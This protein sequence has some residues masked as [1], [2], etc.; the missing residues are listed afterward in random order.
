MTKLRVQRFDAI[1]ELP[2]SVLSFWTENSKDYP[3]Q[4]PNWLL[5]WWDAYSQNAPKKACMYVVFLD[6]QPIAVA[7]FY[8]RVPLLGIRSLRLMGDKGTCTDH[9]SLIIDPL[10]ADVASS[11]LARTLT[12]QAG[13]IWDTL[14]FE[15]VDLE[16]K[17]LNSLIRS[18]QKLKLQFSTQNALDCWV[19]KLQ[20]TWDQYL[21]SLSKNHRK[22]CRRWN[23]DYFDSGRAHIVEANAE[24][25]QAAWQRLVELNQL[26]RAKKADKSSFDEV[27]FVDS[28]QQFLER[29]ILEG[30]ASIRELY[31]DGQHVASEYVLFGRDTVY[32]YQ[33]GMLT[34]ETGDGF[35]NLSL[36]ALVKD[37]IE[38]GYPKIDFLRGDEAYKQHWTAEPQHTVTWRASA[39]CLTGHVYRGLREMMDLVR[40]TKSLIKEGLTATP[41]ALSSKTQDA[42]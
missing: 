41:P 7:P 11:Q 33:S 15:S 24:T 21:M 30:S 8:L 29:A 3:M 19:A 38:R 31:V 2:E 18:M 37:A 16:D 1:Q 40:D 4:S 23:K 12:E 34:T 13:E 32:C 26:R 42:P 14:C 10:H 20:P 5:S 27:P 9:S 22:R 17:Y 6:D 36:L 35:G 28:H 39:N 25:W